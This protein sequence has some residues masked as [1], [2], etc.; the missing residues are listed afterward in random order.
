MKKIFIIAGHQKGTGACSYI[1]EGAE[2]IFLKNEISR[3][4]RSKNIDV[5]NDDDDDKLTQVVDVL[6]SKVLK[7]DICIDIHFNSSSNINTSGTEVF[8]PNNYTIDEF[9][10]ASELKETIVAVLQTKNRGVKTEDMT[11][12]KK[13]AMLS[14]FDCCNIL[15]EICF[16][17]N[18][19]DVEKYNKNKY[20]LAEKLAQKIINFL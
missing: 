10:L 3:I 4:L 2:A 7:N 16:V 5:Y 11:Y 8:I 13:I 12:L 9:H 17:S 19:Q 20:L 18:R 6:K 15:L 14:N 1:E